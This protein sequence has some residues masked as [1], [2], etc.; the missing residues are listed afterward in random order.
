MAGLSKEKHDKELLEMIKRAGPGYAI[1]DAAL[2]A[3]TKIVRI[4]LTT[5]QDIARMLEQQ[6]RR[7]PPVPKELPQKAATDQEEKLILVPGY[8][9]ASTTLV[10]LIKDAATRV[11][12]RRQI[13]GEIGKGGEYYALV[14]AVCDAHGLLSQKGQG[15]DLERTQI[16][17]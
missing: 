9:K 15:E 17:P 7:K 8:G 6:G 16:I 11:K 3:D 2:L 5:V 12:S 13:L 4:P 1:M 14:R 10:M